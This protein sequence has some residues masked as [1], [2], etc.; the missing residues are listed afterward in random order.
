[1]TASEPT[2]TLLIADDD[3]DLSR[4]LVRAFAQRGWLVRTA[5]TG[6]EAVALARSGAAIDAAIVDLVLPGT[7][8]L[9]VVKELRG[10]NPRCRIIA[11]S[12][13]VSAAARDA[14]LQAGANLFLAKPMD[15]D[16]LIDAASG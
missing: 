2:R 16:A 13:V 3:D 8:G 1:M 4:V 9:D 11:V 15:L 14:F 12:G 10:S 6:A 5:R 7:G